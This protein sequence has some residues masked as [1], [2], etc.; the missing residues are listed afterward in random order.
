MS[1]QA[2]CDELLCC[3]FGNHLHPSR[4]DSFW[5]AFRR[6]GSVPL[7]FLLRPIVSQSNIRQRQIAVVRARQ[8]IVNNRLRRSILILAQK[9]FVD[10]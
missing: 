8:W 1:I 10:P 3:L 4:G 2:I 6:A 7:R 9:V 5:S